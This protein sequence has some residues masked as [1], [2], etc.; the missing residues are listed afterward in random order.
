MLVTKKYMTIFNISSDAGEYI[1]LD[2]SKEP[3]N[4]PPVIG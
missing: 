3:I 4:N 1:R 2:D